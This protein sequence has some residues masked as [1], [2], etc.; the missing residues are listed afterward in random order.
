VED[1]VDCFL[2]SLSAPDKGYLLQMVCELYT[3]V[4]MLPQDTV[5]ILF[6]LCLT[7]YEVTQKKK[8]EK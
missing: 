7:E 3:K 6:Q 8:I 4:S 5:Y 1:L 2:G